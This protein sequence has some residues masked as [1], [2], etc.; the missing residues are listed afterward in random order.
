MPRMSDLETVNVHRRGHAA[1]IEL[2]RPES[3]ERVE[4]AVRRSTCWPPSSRSPPTTTCARSAS[5]APGARFSSGADLKDMSSREELTPEGRPDVYKVLTERYHPIITG[6]RTM[7][8]PVLAAVNGPA[9]GIGL[10]LAL[11][12]DLVVARESA[13]FLLAFV[14]I[15]LVPDGGSSLFVP[16]RIG[17]TRAAEMA[18]LGERVPAPRRPLEWGL[19]QPRRSPTTRFD[20]RGRGAARP[21]GGRR[22]RAPTPAPSASSTRGCTSA[23]TTS[24]SSRRRSSG[25]WPGSADFVEGVAAFLQKRRGP[26]PAAADGS[27]AS[28]RATT[29]RRVRVRRRPASAGQRPSPTAFVN[30]IPAALDTSRLRNL[31]TSRRA[32]PGPARRAGR[33]PGARTGRLRRADHPGARAVRRTPTTSTRSTCSSSSSAIVV[34]VGVEGLLLYSVFKFKAR[35]GAVPAQ[36]RGNTRLEIGWTVGAAVILVVLATL[37]FVKLDDIRN[38]PDSVGHTA[39]SWP[40]TTPPPARRT[41]SR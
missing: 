9:V 19:D 36:I 3:H 15:G 4:P 16:E 8:K 12:A 21:P 13:Y 35:K 11:T 7:P 40:D 2:N 10:S 24:S 25:R 30:R 17:F 1:T 20:G 26:V 27:A 38:P 32:I 14:N 37:T 18:M 5:P 22:R 6:L 31:M 23:W 41:A 28:V 39:C 29:E 34:F 33:R